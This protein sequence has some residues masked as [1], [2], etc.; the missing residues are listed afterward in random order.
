MIILAQDLLQW[1]S[2]NNP[3]N[4]P[5]TMDSK[6]TGYHSSSNN[7]NHNSL[8]TE[9]EINWIIKQSVEEQYGYLSAKRVTRFQE[10]ASKRAEDVTNAKDL[11][12]QTSE[13]QQ[14]LQETL[15]S[16]SVTRAATAA[17]SPLHSGKGKSKGKDAALG[18]IVSS[19][20]QFNTASGGG[21]AGLN[22]VFCLDES[23]SM[24]GY[25]PFD[26]NNPNTPWKDL[27]KAFHGFL[28]VRSDIGAD[29]AISVVQF[30]S[31]A[32]ITLDYASLIEAKAH[33]L[34]MQAGATQFKP[35]LNK[36]IQLFQTPGVHHRKPKILVFMS[37]GIPLSLSLSLSFSLSFSLFLSLSHTHFLSI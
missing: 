20:L 13:Y 33:N 26:P 8:I 12:L 25:S 37:D 3:N 4:S 31:F 19:L 5:V 22:I 16:S 23:G 14:L 17:K 35:P 18:G 2:G 9:A 34:Q 10:L 7:N 24:A 11:H 32:R 27:V 28:K 21:P 36:T 6:T 15:Q 1:N 30:A 29:D